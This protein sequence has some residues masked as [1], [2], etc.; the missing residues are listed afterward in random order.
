MNSKTRHPDPVL[1]DQLRAGLLDDQT[2][3]KAQLEKHLQQ[4]EQCQQANAWKN[5][6]DHTVLPVQ[7]EPRLETIRKTAST[8]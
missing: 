6:A 1:L 2:Q 8:V 5:I 3:L 7:L 4:C